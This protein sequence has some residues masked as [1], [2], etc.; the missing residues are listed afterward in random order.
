[1]GA[2]GSLRVC[3]LVLV[4]EVTPEA[5]RYWH[6]LQET[7]QQLYG[8]KTHLRYSAR[9]TRLALTHPRLLRHHPLLQLSI[10]LT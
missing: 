4:P 3:V 1:M 2:C 7:L 9:A 10:H 5:L 8:C 6:T